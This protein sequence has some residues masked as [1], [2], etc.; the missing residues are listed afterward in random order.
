MWNLFAMYQLC[1][2]QMSWGISHDNYVACFLLHL[3]YF[4]KVH[5]IPISFLYSVLSVKPS[6]VTTSRV[7]KGRNIRVTVL[8][9]TSGREMIS[10]VI[11]T[12][13]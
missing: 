8:M 2:Y 11:D 3:F 12:I 7:T 5:Y 1:Y 10:L 6:L 4:L 13:R 9:S